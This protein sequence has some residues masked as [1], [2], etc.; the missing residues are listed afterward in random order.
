MTNSEKG[1]VCHSWACRNLLNIGSTQSL[2]FSSRQELRSFLYS[3]YSII[4]IIVITIFFSTVSAFSSHNTENNSLP[5]YE[6]VI[7]IKM[8]EE[9]DIQDFLVFNDI[10]TKID[11]IDINKPYSFFID[12]FQDEFGLS[13]IFRITYKDDID[14]TKLCDVFNNENIVEY[15]EPLYKHELTIIPNDPLY[16]DQYELRAIKMEECWDISTGDPNVTIA[17]VDSELDWRHR[18][19][20]GNIYENPGE[21]GSDSQGKDKRFNGI[22]DDGNGLIDDY[23]GWDFMSN[24]TYA[25]LLDGKIKQ[26][27]DP[28]INEQDAI[29]FH[30]TSVA[31]VC[32]AVSDNARG[33]ASPGWSCRLMP[34][35]IRSDHGIGGAEH[36]GILYAAM[37]GADVINC[38]W[39][40]VGFSQHERDVVKQ[41]VALGSLIIAS[42]GNSGESIDINYYINSQN[43]M[44]IGASDQND[45]IADF[46]DYGIITALYA[47]GK[48]IQCASPF[49]N[50]TISNGTSLSAPL[51]SGVAGLIKSQ[52]PDWTNFQLWHQLRSTSDNI[53]E[54]DDK[55][56]EYHYGRLNAHKC[57]QY[58]DDFD[59][60]LFIPG[61]RYTDH[62]IITES[63]RID[64]YESFLMKL[65]IINYL[66]PANDLSISIEPI[67]SLL[68]AESQFTV[69]NLNTLES[70]EAEFKVKL[71]Q[72]AKWYDEESYVLVRFKSAVY[73]D[74][75]LLKLS[76][77]PPPLK[78]FTVEGKLIDTLKNEMGEDLKPYVIHSPDIDISWIAGINNDYA[79]FYAIADSNGIY[80]I[81]EF[82][83]NIS[84]T[85]IELFALDGKTC[86]CFMFINGE[87][88]TIWKTTDAG[89][90]WRN[91]KLDKLIEYVP[92]I[93][94]FN[95]RYGFAIVSYTNSPNNMLIETKDFG[96]SWSNAE[97]LLDEDE[98]IMPNK[99]SDRN[100]LITNKNSIF[101]TKDIG[102]SW[103]KDQSVLDTSFYFQNLIYGNR[104][105]SALI[106][107][108]EDELDYN[109]YFAFY[110]QGSNDWIIQEEINLVDILGEPPF[111]NF[112]SVAGSEKY[113]VFS[114]VKN[115][116]LTDDNGINWYP[117]KND[118]SEYF[119]V[120]YNQISSLASN[121]RQ[122]RLWITDESG[123]IAYL[124]LDDVFTPPD[125]SKTGV[126]PYHR[127]FPNPAFDK[128][129]IQYYISRSSNVKISVYDLY[130]RELFSESITGE[131]YKYYNSEI[132][133]SQYA[134]GVYF[135]N[136]EAYGNIVSDKILIIKSY[137]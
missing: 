7:I 121:G 111:D 14:P 36:Q 53:F 24:T 127:A 129:N 35:K 33:M 105:K 97:I 27:N 51:V 91:I 1:T 45:E 78:D 95:P 99:K 67:D 98:S 6:N 23:H 42:A 103:I 133:V 72:N 50:Y 100:I 68:L 43:V 84:G 3:C 92:V 110:H 114:D 21:S 46:S 81:G 118:L 130:G 30:G 135:Y 57:L 63:G 49:D 108:R 83:N 69:E 56:R 85:P 131:P 32:S 37:M 25:E 29:S 124:D 123:Q 116:M 109:S 75:Q 132:D 44:Y 113:V 26:D 39:V 115:F 20:S 79:P 52:H 120:N 107:F 34:V 15:A 128:L 2:Y 93:S 136:I 77:D 96:E 54:S 90:S 8:S 62:K 13:R 41:A 64:T 4:C 87:S 22:D 59:S 28:R 17:I 76:I 60:E 101:E 122:A 71:S 18:D 48:D 47:P 16:S 125:T 19:L 9:K 38:S 10:K 11:I 80:K 66:A 82:G 134:D 126:I 88:N 117:I 55:K 70:I 40:G 112:F 106:A 94:F 65:N 31:S 102:R 137:Y 12:N 73:E 61:I 58:N 89:N 5:Y 74:F 104:G 119:S 86:F